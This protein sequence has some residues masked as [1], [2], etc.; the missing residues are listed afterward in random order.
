MHSLPLPSPTCNG[1]SWF[2]SC[3]VS[4]HSSCC[5]GYLLKDGTH[6]TIELC[7]AGTVSFWT[8]DPLAVGS[9]RIPK[10]D[11]LNCIACSALDTAL[12]TTEWAHTFAP[13][14]G[15]TQCVPCPGGTIPKNTAGR[16][17][18]CAACPNGTY[19][20]AYTIRLARVLCLVCQVGSHVAERYCLCARPHESA[21]KL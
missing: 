14:K 17:A 11:E 7:P 3:L 16:T 2:Q 5:V 9:E 6:T 21:S 15:M 13:R 10:G 8:A 1:S 19:R 12:T 4:R 18:S 20:D